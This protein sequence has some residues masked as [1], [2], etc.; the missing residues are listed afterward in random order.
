MAV[1]MSKI[2]SVPLAPGTLA[3]ITVTAYPYR[4]KPVI[5]SDVISAIEIRDEA[6]K[7]AVEVSFTIDNVDRVAHTYLAPGTWL[8]VQ[9]KSPINGDT[10][11]IT[12]R[13]YVWERLV[14]DDRRR[15]ATLTALDTVSFLQRQGQ[16]SYFF[17]KGMKSHPK[18]WTA[19]EIA[20]A[21]LR[22]LGVTAEVIPTSY[23]INWFL[24]QDVTPYEAIL[25]AYMR[26]KQITGQTYRI[27]A[28]KAT[29]TPAGGIDKPGTVVIEPVLY[30]D[31]RWLLSDEENI[32]SA[33]RS[34][35]LDDVATEYIGV[36]LNKNGKELTRTKVSSPD[37]AQY[38]TLRRFEVL[39]KGTQP[40]DAERVARKELDKFRK[41]KRT[42]RVESLGTVTL[43]ASDLVSIK[44]AGTGLNGNY[45]VS[46]ISHSLSAA[47]HQ[48]EVEL[49][50]TAKYPTIDVE[51]SEWNP[52]ANRGGGSDESTGTGGAMGERA[53]AWAATQKGVPYVYGGNE[54]G[55]GLDCSSLCMFAWKYAGKSIPRTTFEQIKIGAAVSSI[56]QA[57]P[58]DLVFYG[59][60]H[61]ALYAGNN[62]QWEARRTGTRISLN[63]VRT[64]SVT[65]I[66]RPVPL[67]E[68]GTGT[69]S[70]GGTESSGSSTVK[71]PAVAEEWQYASGQFG[72]GGGSSES[73]TTTAAGSTVSADTLKSALT[74]RNVAPFLANLAD[75]FVN[76]GSQYGIDPIFLAAIACLESG[77]GKH[78]P[79]I[80]TK[81]IMGYAGGP[82]SKSFSTYEACVFATAGPT[83][84]SGDI[85]KGRDTISSIGA[86]YAPAGAANDSGG[87]SRW[88]ATV[89]AIYR[90]LGGANPSA[91]V[92]GSGYRSRIG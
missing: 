81:N 58:G 70:G 57:A 79:A 61:I 80:R 73:T 5:L 30:Q 11:N 87:N 51:E 84:L 42:A 26:D 75:T 27:R 56:S 35:S 69:G 78:G 23:R 1:D 91:P 28:G 9:G 48:M 20:T 31:Y 50:Y 62:Q 68:Q 32:M 10:I 55:R 2:R 37:K 4:G 52:S 15:T 54:P 44:D 3:E 40:K 39:P 6:E 77:N 90:E 43:R 38:G 60:G 86:K 36:V 16:Q 8:T 19:S 12:P 29:R 7:C 17:R 46:T 88:P 89:S 47:G 14:S 92:K 85:Y 83:A 65:A 76:A 33:E 64:G 41:L 24:L 13:L 22:D 53:V 25:K 66:R 59:T 45:F 21:I 18:G 34:E 74:R 49:S 72:G 82:A 67:S 71:V 63:P